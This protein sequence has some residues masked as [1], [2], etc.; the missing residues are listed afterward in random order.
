MECNRSRD[1]EVLELLGGGTIKQLGAKAAERLK[2][3][4][5]KVWI[6]IL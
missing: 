6:A 1:I 4:Y 5:T 3:K 2:I